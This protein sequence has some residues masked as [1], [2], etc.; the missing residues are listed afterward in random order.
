[1]DRG[2]RPLPFMDE[3]ITEAFVQAFERTG[4]RYLSDRRVAEVA[5][6]GVSHVV[7]RLEDGETVRG[8]KMLVALGRVANLKGLGIQAAG[9][10]ATPRGL[11]QVDDH[12]QTAVPGI[13]AAGDMIGFPALAASSMEQGRQAIC[14]ALGV[15]AGPGDGV[16]PTGIHTIPEMASVGLD[17]SHAREQFGSAV[18]G[19]AGFEEIARGQI[20]HCQ[21]GLLKLVADDRGR[22]LLGAQIVG[23]SATELIHVAQMALLN[24]CE[25]GVFVENIFNF[26]T[27][28]EAYRVAALKIENQVSARVSK[29]GM[30]PRDPKERVPPLPQAR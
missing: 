1:I 18:V 13:Y 3:E 11:I 2:P 17:E 15:G 10:V 21:D 4:S 19:C 8:E 20:S 23:A 9:L 26:P 7:T 27:L 30:Q 25:T 6:D 22:R 29:T 24:G 5:F 14:H 12:F 28:A 16:I